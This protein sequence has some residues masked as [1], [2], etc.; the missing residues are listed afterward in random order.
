ML[1]FEMD[2]STKDSKL[3]LH[4]FFKS[5]N[6][7][8]NVVFNFQGSAIDDLIAFARGYHAAGKHLAQRMAVAPGY[9][10]YDGYPIL[11]LYRHSLELHLKAIVIRGAKLLGLISEEKINTQ[12]LWKKHKFVGLLPA[13]ESI[14]NGMQWDWDFEVSGLRSW[15]DFCALVNG[16]EQ[17]D[18]QSYNF[19]YPVDTSGE[20][21]LPKHLVLNIV[22]FARR[23]DPVLDLLYGA[24]A[25]IQ[26]KWD[27]VAEAAYFI[28]EL[29]KDS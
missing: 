11:F 2:S 20:A 4:P 29:F 22:A 16:I 15:D 12:N 10:D 9:R 7:H 8:G 19:R 3:V 21:A 18:P 25:G 24:V 14:F 1:D 26:E 13:V 6:G 23:M 28:Q 27:N 17:I 5:D